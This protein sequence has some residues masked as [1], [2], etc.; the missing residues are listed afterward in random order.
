MQNARIDALPPEFANAHQSF[1]TRRVPREVMRTLVTGALRPEPGQLVLARVRQPGQHRNVELISGRKAQLFPDDL[2]ILAYGNRYA[3][4]QF[5]AL[6]PLDLG[7]CDMVAGGGIAAREVERNAAM[8]APTRIAPLGLLGNSDGVPLNLRDFRIAHG[9]NGIAAG[10]PVYVVCGSSMNAGKTHTVAM[11]VRGLSLGGRRVAAC[12]V[13]GTGAGNDTWRM[14]DAGAATVLDFTDA[15]HPSTYGVA[16]E[17]LEQ[18]YLDLVAAAAADAE[19]VVVEIA[20]GLGQSETAGLMRSRTLAQHSTGVLFAAAD[21][22]AAVA[23]ERW[24]R[25]AGLNVLAVSGLFT[26]CATSTLEAQRLLAVPVLSAE[27][28]AAG[29]AFASRTAQ[30]A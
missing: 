16:V 7:P 24:L 11:L 28:L 1:A 12:K 5:E 14:R 9:T 3:P 22:L 13:T 15:G 21:P 23:G 25:E 8:N 26:A 6:V 2:V 20:D 10:V 27:Q 18:V 19:A 4:D 29:P 30:A 17:E